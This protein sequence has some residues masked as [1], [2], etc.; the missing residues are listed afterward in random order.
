GGARKGEQI[1]LITD[2]A[3]A[4]RA[5]IAAFVRSHGVQNT[6]TP[7]KIILVEEVPILGTG[8]IDYAAVQRLAA[9]KAANVEGASA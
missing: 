8:K 2:C 5:D 6:A 4:T 7:E 1:V 9:E 3:E